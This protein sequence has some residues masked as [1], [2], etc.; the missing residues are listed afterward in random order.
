MPQNTNSTPCFLFI[1]LQLP[2]PLAWHLCK[3]ENTDMMPT[4]AKQLTLRRRS[5]AIPQPSVLGIT[6][7]SKHSWENEGCF[8]CGCV[9]VCVWANA[10]SHGPTVILLALAFVNEDDGQIRFPQ[11]PQLVTATCVRTYP[12]CVVLF[13]EI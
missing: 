8:G 4:E 9:C 3:G 13:G 1:C 2:L 12:L 10:R 5:D 11:C 7:Y 6:V